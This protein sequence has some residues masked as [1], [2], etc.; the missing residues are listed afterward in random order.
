MP[1]RPDLVSVINDYKN[2]KLKVGKSFG[3]LSEFNFNPLEGSSR[4]DGS[5]RDRLR[6]RRNGFIQRKRD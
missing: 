4:I 1:L 6:R 3:V 2:I 5:R